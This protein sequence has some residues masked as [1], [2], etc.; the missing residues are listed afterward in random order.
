M[1]LLPLYFTRTG[2]CIKVFSFK[3]HEGLFVSN[4]FALLPNAVRHGFE[5]LFTIV[6]L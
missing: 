4:L 5:V 3:L 2:R 6:Y 1:M